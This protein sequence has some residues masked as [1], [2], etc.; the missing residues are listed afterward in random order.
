MNRKNNY[1]VVIAGPTAVGKTTTS[2]RVAKHFGSVVISA[3]SR[4]IYRELK[5]GTSAPTENQRN[6]V[7]H[8]FVSNKSIHDPF[9]ASIYEAEV[10]I[11][12]SGLFKIHPV[13]I[14][15]G[16]SGL[17]IDAVRKGIDDLPEVDKK[18]R[19]KVQEQFN[20]EGIESLRGILK[21]WILWPIPELI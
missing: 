8:F 13:I 17:Y 11:L 2:I 1:L 3:D 4:Q 10:N 15:A 20:N 19:K 21:Y 14:L 9:N 5:I 12:L 16:G 7:E 18:I 6:E